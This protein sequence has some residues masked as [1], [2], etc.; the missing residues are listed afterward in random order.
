MQTR[1]MILERAG[2]NVTQARDLR[3][4]I[5]ACRSGIFALAILGQSLPAKEKLRI[6]G[7]I[8]RECPGAKILELHTGLAGELPSADSHLQVTA[9]APEGLVECVETLT[10][11]EK[12]RR[13]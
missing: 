10:S 13:A 1:L 9:G 11:K 6:S 8:R 12:R 5:A 4:I 7:V 2:H 3:E